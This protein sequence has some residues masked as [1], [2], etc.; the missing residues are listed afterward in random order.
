ME[1]EVDYS[2]SSQSLSELISRNGWLSK[3]LKGS[4]AAKMGKISEQ[5][6]ENWMNSGMVWHG[7]FWMQN[8]LEHPNDVVESSLSQVIKTQAPLMY[9]LHTDHLKSLLHRAQAKNRPLPRDLKLAVERQISILSNMPELE[10][11]LRQDHKGQDIEVMEKPGHLTE[12]GVQTLYVRRMLPSEYEIL[13]GF[14][15]NWTDR[16]MEP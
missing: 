3:T 5:S 11:N 9:F 14:P 15:E 7:E 4:S 8:T 1:K 13:Q 16:D 2:L 12:E 10:E 6:S